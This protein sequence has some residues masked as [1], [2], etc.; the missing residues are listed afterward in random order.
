MKGNTL[1]IFYQDDRSDSDTHKSGSSIAL[2][3]NKT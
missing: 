2:Q 1:G 3:I